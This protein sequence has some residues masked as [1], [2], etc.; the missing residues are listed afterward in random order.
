MIP[1]GMQRLNVSRRIG[2]PAHPLVQAEAKSRKPMEAPGSLGLDKAMQVTCTVGHWTRVVSQTQVGPPLRH[3]TPGW[4]VT[5]SR[6]YS[7]RGQ[8]C[9]NPQGNEWTSSLRERYPLANK[10]K[11]TNTHP[12]GRTHARTHTDTQIRARAR[13][14]TQTHKHTN[15]NTQTQIHTRTH[16]HTYTHAHAHAHAHTHT[17]THTHTYHTLK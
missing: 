17:Q 5:L 10:H 7:R 2:Y 16:T 14:H 1:R 9:T 12:C 8:R 15:T 3:R 11:H 4:Q 13:T 6:S